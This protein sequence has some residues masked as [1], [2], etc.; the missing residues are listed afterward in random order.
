MEAIIRK[1]LVCRLGLSDG[2]RPY[3]VPMSFGYEDDTLYFHGGATGTKAQILRKN[4]RVSFEFDVDVEISPSEQP[5]KWGL[6]YRSV[7]GRGTAHFIED[8]DEKRKALN[9]IMRHYAAGSFEF[10][11]SAVQKVAVFRVDVQAMN[12]KQAGY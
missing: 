3:V 12:G 5:C 10:P 8:P 11:E 2:E 6:K 9:V 4:N 7:I 1:A